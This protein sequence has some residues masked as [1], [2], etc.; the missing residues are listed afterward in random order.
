MRRF[1]DIATAQ[2]QGLGR[3]AY[4][5]N[6][7]FLPKGTPA[8]IVDKLNAAMVAVMATP[9]VKQRVHQLGATVPPPEQRTPNTCSSFVES[10]IKTWGAVIKAAGMTAE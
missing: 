2:E 5:W 3:R 9:A 6:A 4:S 7:I 10:E 8:P 1:P